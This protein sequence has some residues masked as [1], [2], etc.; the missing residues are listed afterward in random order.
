MRY[1]HAIQAPY[2]GGPTDANALKSDRFLILA[3]FLYSGPVL[4][5]GTEQGDPIDTW[6]YFVL[7]SFAYETF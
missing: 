2:R 7:E 6:K 4:D 5:F 3:F 1:G